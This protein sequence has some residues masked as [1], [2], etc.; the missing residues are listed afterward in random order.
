MGAKRCVS[1]F[2]FVL[3]R[4]ALGDT[5]CPGPGTPGTP[6]VSSLLQVVEPEKE[7]KPEPT[8][9]TQSAKLEPHKAAAAPASTKH[10]AEVASATAH[11][12][13][14]G[15]VVATTVT[16]QTP[17]KDPSET[18]L[19]SMLDAFGNYLNRLLFG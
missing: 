13:G 12:P 8:Q 19:Q 4:V 18:M 7:A 17:P 2:L 1:L 5:A 14:K 15:K 11:E 6:D 10:A 3:C 16:K 9:P